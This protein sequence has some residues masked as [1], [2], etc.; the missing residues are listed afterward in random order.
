MS[1]ETIKRSEL[2]RM[3]GA[4]KDALGLSFKDF[5]VVVGVD[6]GYVTSSLYS[7]TEMVSMEVVENL[8]APFIFGSYVPPFEKKSSKEAAEEHWAVCP[9][10]FVPA[11]PI[12]SEFIQIKEELGTTW[13]A[14][15]DYLD[16]DRHFL[17][18]SFNCKYMTEE[19]AKKLKKHMRKIRTLPER[20]K[21]ERFSTATPPQLTHVDK[22][23][24]VAMLFQ[25]KAACDPP[26]WKELGSRTGIDSDRLRKVKE[27][28]SAKMRKSLY[29]EFSN[30]VLPILEE[31][32]RRN[33]IVNQNID[34][35]YVDERGQHKARR[36]K[37][38][39]LFKA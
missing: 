29:E 19:R 23:S 16:E 5:A 13:V 7:K 2:K 17:S 8:L 27:R 38:K 10:G 32:E 4:V 1:Q 20:T 34:K 31:A 11:E 36:R 39:G 30:A 12:R 18:S 37:I 15:A 35:V 26:T 6:H 28:K 14:L 9:K 22:R 33:N 25:A 21:L 3:V 24:L